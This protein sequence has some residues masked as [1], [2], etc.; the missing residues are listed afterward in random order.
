MSLEQTVEALRR[1]VRALRAEAE[2]RRVLMEYM[3]LCDTPYPIFGGELEDRVTAVAS[4]FTEDAIWEGVGGAHGQQFGQN[5]GRQ[6][7]AD[8]MRRF[9]G[10]NHA[11]QIFNTHYVSSGQVWVTENGAEG[12]WPQFQPWIY[13]DGKSLIRSSRVHVKFRETA[14]GWKICH[15]R[16]ENLF[17]GDLPDNWTNTLIKEAV[18]MKPAD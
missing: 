9:Y 12:I 15:Y 16:T 2:A 1:E 5:V 18:L 13:A 8:H 17:I 3:Y 7:I 14:D 6:A 4:V 11:T 10:G